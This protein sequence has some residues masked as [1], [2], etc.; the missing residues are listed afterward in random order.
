MGKFVRR[1]AKAFNVMR[2]LTIGK[3]YV[4]GFALHISQTLSSMGHEV[5]TWEPGFKGERS[6]SR[7]GY[8]LDQFGGILYELSDNLSAFRKSRMKSLWR[9]VDH[10]NFDL[11]LVCHDFL[12]PSEVEAL[13]LK[14]KS[15]VALWFP[16]SI[17]NFG[18]AYFM[19]SPYDAIFFKDPYIV[20]ILGSFLK[21]PIF[22]LPECFNP[23]LHSSAGITAEERKLY[24]CEVVT[25]GNQH[26]WRVAI[27]DQLSDFDVKIWGNAPPLW[28]PK[29]ATSKKYQGRGL[30]NREKAIAF[31][32]AKIVVNNLLYSEIWGLNARCFEAAGAGAFQLVDW[33]PGIQNLFSLDSEIVTYKGMNDLVEKIR[34]WLPRQE[35]RVAISEAAELRARE[36]HTYEQRLALMMST[37]KGAERGYELPSLAQKW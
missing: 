2:I 18:R 31:K 3:F 37:L 8:R 30:Y 13:K 25:A 20:S 16:D 15:M 5:S 32:S 21:M 6:K 10:Q 1:S 9:L 11:I 34:Y 28:M 12:R 29:S 17:A 36:H 4:E 7:I 22:Y 27:F 19:N 26:S 23:K 33:R 14:S 24:E 35:E